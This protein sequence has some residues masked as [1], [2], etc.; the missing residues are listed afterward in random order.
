M[1][2][3]GYARVS[4]T[5]QELAGQV[6]ELH[7]A[8]CTKIYREKASGAKTDRAELA[9]LPGRLEAGDGLIGWRDQ[10]GILQRARYGLEGWRRLPILEGYLGRYDHAP[11][12]FARHR[13]QRALFRLCSSAPLT[14]WAQDMPRALRGRAATSP[15]LPC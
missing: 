15:A 6:A 8:G 2:V 13:R 7:T 4:T 5:G 14:R 3:I 11:S 12:S 10:P 9:K 1:A